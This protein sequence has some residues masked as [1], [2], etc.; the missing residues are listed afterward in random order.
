[1]GQK[2][3][4][5]DEKTK[6]PEIVKIGKPRVYHIQL[7]GR[8]PLLMK[9]DDLD[10]ARRMKDWEKDP[11]NKNLSVPG[12]DRTPPWRWLG[13]LYHDTKH[14][15]I[16]SD[17]LMAVFGAGGVNVNTGFRQKTFKEQSQS[18]ALVVEESWPLNIGGKLIPVE[19][20][21]ASIRKD[22]SFDQHK[23]LAKSLGFSLFVN[24]ARVPRRTGKRHVRVRPR[25]DNWTAEGTL[26]VVDPMITLTVV[27]AIW[28]QAGMYKGIGDWRPSSPNKP[29]PF[30]T[31]EVAVR[32]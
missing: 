23:E 12:D 27:R 26:Q 17:M 31:F 10:W 7:V 21:H 22:L 28:S 16:P 13:C 25:F 24:G 15:G 2:A 11:E 18:G 4:K 32:E 6:G 3:V 29:G 30:G 8:M 5:D 20:L 9:A 1:M 14:V 19:R